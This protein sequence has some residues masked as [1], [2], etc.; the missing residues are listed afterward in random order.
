[1][2]HLL[3]NTWKGNIFPN[4]VRDTFVDKVDMKIN[5][6]CSVEKETLSWSNSIVT[7]VN[8]NNINSFLIGTEGWY[9]VFG[10]LVLCGGSQS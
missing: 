5:S 7:A 9:C 6:I 2:L 10:R 8:I 3:P 1:M 4:L